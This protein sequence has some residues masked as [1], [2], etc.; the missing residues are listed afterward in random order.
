MIKVLMAVVVVGCLIGAA[1]QTWQTI[2]LASYE[3][4]G[5]SGAV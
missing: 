3:K 2:K 4:T 1:R 5:K